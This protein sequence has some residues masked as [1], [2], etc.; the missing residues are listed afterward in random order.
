MKKSNMSWIVT[1]LKKDIHGVEAWFE[2]GV[3]NGACGVAKGLE[4]EVK[5]GIRRIVTCREIEVKYGIR[6]LVVWFEQKHNVHGVVAC[7]EKGEIDG[8]VQQEKKEGSH[9]DLIAQRACGF[10]VGQR[11]LKR[12]GGGRDDFREVLVPILLISA[13]F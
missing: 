9:R 2:K 11:S 13:H 1:L 3:K 5:W 12:S 6:S 10:A 4:L 8:D 7:H